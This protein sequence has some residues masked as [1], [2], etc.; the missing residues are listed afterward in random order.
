MKFVG[1]EGKRK[2]MNF[3]RNGTEAGWIKSP[4]PFV[5]EGFRRINFNRRVAAHLEEEL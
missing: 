1:M 4:S 2:G 5:S 3:K